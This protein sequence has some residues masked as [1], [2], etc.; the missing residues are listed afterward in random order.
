MWTE[1]IILKYGET[2]VSPV[3]AN[4]F[5]SFSIQT[6]G[7]ERPCLFFV[8]KPFGAHWWLRNV[9]IYV[10]LSYSN[11]VDVQTYAKYY[12]TYTIK[13]KIYQIIKCSMMAY[14]KRMLSFNT[15]LQ[16]G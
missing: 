7:W 8:I 14:N 11:P 5:A 12:S 4:T 6:L 3:A 9:H 16:S 15:I 2:N 10:Y 1:K 13:I